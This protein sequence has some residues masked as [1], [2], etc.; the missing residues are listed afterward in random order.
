MESAETGARADGPDAAASSPR[1]DTAMTPRRPAGLRARRFQRFPKGSVERVDVDR[2]A[3]RSHGPFQRGGVRFREL[4]LER[5]RHGYEAS[6]S[7]VILG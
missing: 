1:R 2:R 6:R 7:T 4:M 3:A 5:A